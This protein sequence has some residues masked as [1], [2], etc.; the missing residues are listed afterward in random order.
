MA[1]SRSMAKWRAAGS[2]AIVMV[3]VRSVRRALLSAGA[4]VVVAAGVAM[5][6]PASAAPGS[7]SEAV[8]KAAGNGP[9]P[10]V[11]LVHGA[12]A[13]ASGFDTV[14]ARLLHDGYPVR[15]VADPL[16]GIAN[17]A[18]ATN[19]V[20]RSIKGPIVLVGHSYGGAVI[21]NSA[22]GNPNVKALV[23]LAAL[24]PDVGETAFGPTDVPIQH[25]LP[26]LPIVEVPTVAA[27]GTKGTDMYLATDQF[28]AR[29]ANDVDPATAA[30][31]AVTQR[32]L[33]K[34]AE[35]ERSTAASWK[36][37]P[38]WYLVTE[39]DQGIPP[40]LQHFFAKRAKS[41]VEEV[42]SSHAVF[43]SHPASVVRVIEDAAHGTR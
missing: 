8:G 36:T 18:A 9:K 10:T 41:H 13:D 11:V 32:P 21:T 34:N 42:Y 19:D 17:D 37:I 29:F 33:S 22:V 27:D 26:P 12:Y 4:A 40:E 25:P 20:L 1:P 3:H 30:V 2:A 6:V 31:M 7:K 23:Y 43:I 39:N 28:R 15:T 24:V 35:T 5:A 16:R 38:S 14:I